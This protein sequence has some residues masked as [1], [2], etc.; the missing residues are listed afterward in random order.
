M[1]PGEKAAGKRAKGRQAV[2]KGWGKRGYLSKN[3][4][5]D[6]WRPSSPSPLL[7]TRSARAGCP[8]PNSAPLTDSS[9]E[10]S[11]KFEALK[12][13]VWHSTA[14]AKLVPWG[15]ELRGVMLWKDHFNKAL[16][17]VFQLPT[18]YFFFSLQ[19][20][21][22]IIHA[23][24]KKGMLPFWSAAI[25]IWNVVCILQSRLELGISTLGEFSVF[26]NSFSFQFR[27][28]TLVSSLPTN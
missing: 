11:L 5:R 9:A 18:D 27:Q 8:G 13:E 1:D 6:L 4:D 28:A 25:K 20:L 16:F 23:I 24:W 12:A 3:A 2:I 14:Y 10:A 26:W 21:F 7:R 17:I 15:S 19:I 22:C